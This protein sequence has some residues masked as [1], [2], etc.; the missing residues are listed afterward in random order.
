MKK[1][2]EASYKYYIQ[3]VKKLEKEGKILKEFKEDVKALKQE[4]LN[5]KKDV[6]NVPQLAKK[7]EKLK[8]ITNRRYRMSKKIKTTSQ[9]IQAQNLKKEL[10]KEIKI[11][12]EQQLTRQ[13]KNRL[14]GK[15]KE[16]SELGEAVFTKLNFA[17]IYEKGIYR[18]NKNGK[19]IHYTG[20]NAVRKQIKSLRES[21]D[22]LRKKRLF[23]KI[24]MKNLSDSGINFPEAR[25]ILNSL[26]PEEITYLLNKG[27]IPEISFYYVLDENDIKE[28]AKQFDYIKNK[29]NWQDMY[30]KD[31]SNLEEMK[32]VIKEE[33]KLQKK[34]KK[35]KKFY[36][37]Y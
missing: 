9:K 20:L 31:M 33:N 25:Q 7:V 23:I 28:I 19:V 15:P 18:V 17:E 2:L 29:E 13:A 22:P 11:L 32:Q 21:N 34:Q 8:T 5:N 37:N 12:R 14:I 26:A 30:I 16:A 6:S 27:I 24:Y 36:K 10:K 1:N 3:R 35:A 4:A